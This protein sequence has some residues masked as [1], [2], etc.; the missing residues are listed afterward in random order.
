MLMRSSGFGVAWRGVLESRKQYGRQRTDARERNAKEAVEPLRLNR[1][2][3][4]VLLGGAVR[5]R[6]QIAQ[7][8]LFF[9]PRLS[10]KSMV[11][12]KGEIRWTGLLAMSTVV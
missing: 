8:S 5:F 2:F 10:S 12:G 7:L 9:A 4:V 11:S 3:R 6:Q 1:L